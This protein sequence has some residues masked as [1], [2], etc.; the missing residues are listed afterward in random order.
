[1]VEVADSIVVQVSEGRARIAEWGRDFGVLAAGLVLVFLHYRI[2][3]FGMWLFEKH[4]GLHGV[5]G[6]L[7][8]DPAA[9]TSYGGHAQLV[10]MLREGGM[11]DTPRLHRRVRHSEVDME[12]FS[13]GAESAG[14]PRS[15]DSARRTQ[16]FMH[17]APPGN[18]R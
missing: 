5:R 13:K 11:I 8:G 12:R 14:S 6:T 9:L 3:I 1:M 16:S 17:D 2:V 4:R 10:H 7:G 18:T 15:P